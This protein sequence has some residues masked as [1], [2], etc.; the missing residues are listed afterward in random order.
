[1]LPHA[2]PRD[3]LW[4]CL[5]GEWSGVGSGSYP[6]VPAFRYRERL[7]ITIEPDWSM[8]SVLQ[9]TWRDDGDAAGKALHLE[10]GVLLARDDGTL[11]F[12]CGQDSGRVEAMTGTVAREGGGLR[13][14]WVTVAHGNDDRLVRM[15]RT[16]WVGAR[17]FRYEAHLATVRTPE[18]RKH[19]EAA[20]RRGERA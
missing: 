17:D 16:W 4:H 14:D 5:A 13:I 9:R 11:V 18:Y 12:S 3:E 15:G 2:I 20:L 1:M 19:L 8:L 7:A 6:G 10:A